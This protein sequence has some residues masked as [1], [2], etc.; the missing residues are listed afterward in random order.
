MSHILQV[1]NL[2]MRFGGLTAIGDL[3]FAAPAQQVTF[4][5]LASQHVVQEVILYP[6][7]QT[8]PIAV[9]GTDILIDGGSNDVRP[10][11]FSAKL[12]VR[13]YPN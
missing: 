3:S 13:I 7:N 5:G 9:E 10:V 2:T 8:L 12:H 1:D 11:F 6:S 4:V